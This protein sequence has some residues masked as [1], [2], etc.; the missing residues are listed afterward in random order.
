MKSKKSNHNLP[1]FASTSLCILLLCI[2]CF[3]VGLS[4]YSKSE[5]NS[6]TT[7]GIVCE[8]ERTDY[9]LTDHCSSEDT[10]IENIPYDTITGTTVSLDDKTSL[11]LTC[12]TLKKLGFA[13]GDELDTGDDV[14][15]F[16]KKSE[17]LER[18]NKQQLDDKKATG[19]VCYSAEDAWAQIGEDACVSFRVSMVG[20]SN[21][22]IF[23]DE[24]KDYRSGF[25]AVLKGNFINYDEAKN[26]FLGNEIFVEGSIVRYEGHPEID[27][28]SYKAIGKSKVIGFSTRYGTIWSK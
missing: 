24:K 3:C 26:K 9:G 8:I 4:I 16:N 22:L 1:V 14:I 2:I 20:D 23:L 21:G 17:Q 6:R 19:E 11:N 28:W 12:Y 7:D 15:F 18:I 5:Q 10:S 13:C 27:V 25:V